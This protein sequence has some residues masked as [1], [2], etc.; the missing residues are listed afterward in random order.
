MRSQM[1]THRLRSSPGGTTLFAVVLGALGAASCASIRGIDQDG[2]ASGAGGNGANSANGGTGGNTSINLS[3]AAAPN[4][5][6]AANVDSDNADVAGACQNL[7]C[8]QTTCTKGRCR[9][10][11]CPGGQ[12]T[13]VTGIVFDPAGRV[14]IYNVAVFVPNAP[15]KPL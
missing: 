4:V 7:A 14:P 12:K 5:D 11:A 1:L 2:G 3:D 15:L 6:A 10:P 9:Q 8:Q 13:T